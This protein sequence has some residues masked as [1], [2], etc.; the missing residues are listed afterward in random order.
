MVQRGAS[1]G[2][3]LKEMMRKA[4]LFSAAI[5]DRKVVEVSVVKLFN[6]FINLLYNWEDLP[7]LICEDIN[8][9]PGLIANIN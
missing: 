1:E 3:L 8:T 9:G 2:G 7:E 6:N 5:D 4:L